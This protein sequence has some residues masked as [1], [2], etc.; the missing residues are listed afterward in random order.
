VQTDAGGAIE[1]ACASLPYGDALSC[2]GPTFTT[3]HHFTGKER[4][5]ESGNDYFGARYYASTMGRF[6]SPDWSATEEPVPYAVLGDPQSLNLYAYVRNNPLSR[7]DP[8]GH[9]CIG[10]VIGTTCTPAPPPPPAPPPTPSPGSTPGTIPDPKLSGPTAQQ[11]NA[12]VIGK[13]KDA[14]EKCA[15]PPSIADMAK[16]AAKNAV[17]DMAKDVLTKPDPKDF[18]PAETVNDSIKENASKSLKLQ[19]WCLDLHPLAA[20]DGQYQGTWKPGDYT[21]PLFVYIPTIQPDGS[22]K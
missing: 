13:E 3:E 6:L 1:D 9:W 21:R 2:I 15:A 18:N 7:T 12:Q 16:D 19:N 17:K 8:N 11:V 4:D 20:L 14:F 22:L 10:G 5:T